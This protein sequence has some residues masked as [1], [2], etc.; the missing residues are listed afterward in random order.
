[1]PLPGLPTTLPLVSF[2][3]DLGFDVFYRRLTGAL[4]NMGNVNSLNQL[5]GS[6]GYPTDLGYLYIN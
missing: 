1:M 6:N 2:A 4:S 5:L 3:M